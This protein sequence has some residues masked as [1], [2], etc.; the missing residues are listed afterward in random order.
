LVPVASEDNELAAQLSNTWSVFAV[1]VWGG[2]SDTLHLFQLH[3][4]TVDL[5]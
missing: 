3:Q 2:S 5:Q 4:Y 1:V